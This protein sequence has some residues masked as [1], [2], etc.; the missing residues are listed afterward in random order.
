LHQQELFEKQ[1]Q[2]QQNQRNKRGQKIKANGSK[3]K[4][5]KYGVEIVEDKE[6]E[7][8]MKSQPN[9][10]AFET[11]QDWRSRLERLI[12]NAA[13]KQERVESLQKQYDEMSVQVVVHTS[14]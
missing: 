2:Q 4:K 13:A 6:A 8:E 10:N 5:N 1:Q 11:T 12:Q 7:E 14:L 3:I 9:S